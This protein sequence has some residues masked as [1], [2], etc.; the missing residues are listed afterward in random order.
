MRVREM[1]EIRELEPVPALDGLRRSQMVRWYH[2][3]GRL[4]GGKWAS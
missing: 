2:G 4:L 3:T 1:E